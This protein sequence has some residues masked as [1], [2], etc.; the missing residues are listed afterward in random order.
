MRPR[1]YTSAQLTELAEKHRTQA[2]LAR[3]IGI[4]PAA[5]SILLKRYGVQRQRAKP[6]ER[7]SAAT[8]GNAAW[9]ALGD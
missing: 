6:R 4:C 3:H 7:K 1:K 2:D 8:V 9:Q 5:V